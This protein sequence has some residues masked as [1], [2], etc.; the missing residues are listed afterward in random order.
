MMWMRLLL[1]IIG[2]NFLIGCSEVPV[3]SDARYSAA[4]RKH[5]YKLKKWSFD[6]RISLSDGRESWSAT[7]I[8]SH[9]DGRDE[10][11]LAGP[12][13]QGAAV[14]TLTKNLIIIDRGDDKPKQS[15]QA[16]DFI[17]LQLGISVP[18]RA[19]RYWVLGLTDPSYPFLEAGDGFEQSKWIVHY[20]QMQKLGEEWLPRKI[21]AEQG[22]AKLKLFIDQWVL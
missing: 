15:T 1:L 19:L 14:I 21:G 13:G 22:N 16:D 17:Q 10:I 8:W 2:I 12:L 4:E 5:L 9:D 18:V 7:V 6:G 11:R 20:L 3:K